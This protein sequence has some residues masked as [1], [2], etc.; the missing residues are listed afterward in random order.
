MIEFEISVSIQESQFVCEDRPNFTGNKLPSLR[1]QSVPSGFSVPLVAVHYANP[2]N[3]LI[4]SMSCF[5]LNIRTLCS[6][7]Y[8]KT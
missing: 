3:L 2:Q 4:R 1:C 5:V 8:S 6:F 7:R